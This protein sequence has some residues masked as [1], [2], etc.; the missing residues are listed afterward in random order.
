VPLRLLPV[1]PVAV[2]GCLICLLLLRCCC[3]YDCC[4]LLTLY[5]C[6]SCWL[7]RCSRCVYCVA[8]LFRCSRC[9]IYLLLLL[10]PVVRY[11]C[12]RC[13]F[14]T[15]VCCCLHW[16]DCSTLLRCHVVPIVTLLP[17]VAI[18]VADFVVLLTPICYVTRVITELFTVYCSHV[19]LL[20]YAIAVNVT[21]CQPRCAL[22]VTVTRYVVVC[23][24]TR[25]FVVCYVVVPL[26][27][28]G[29]VIWFCAD[30]RICLIVRFIWLIYDLL[31]LRSC[32]TLLLLFVICCVCL[33]GWFCCTPLAPH[34]A[35]VP[36]CY[37]RC[38][39]TRC[40]R[41]RARFAFATRYVLR[42]FTH[43][44]AL[45]CYHVTAPHVLPY[46]LFAFVVWLH[47]L[48]C[49]LRYLYALL[50]T[51]TALRLLPGRL[52]CLVGT[53]VA[54]LLRFPLLR[55]TFT[56]YVCCFGRSRCSLIRPDFALLRCSYRL[57][58]VYVCELPL[59]C[60]LV[61]CLLRV[62]FVDLRCYVGAV[63]ERYVCCCTLR[64]VVTILPHVYS[65][66]FVLERLFTIYLLLFALRYPLFALLFILLFVVVPH[67]VYVV[68]W[69]YVCCYA[70]ITLRLLL[71]YLLPLLLTLLLLRYHVVVRCRCTFVRFCTLLRCICLVLLPYCP[72]HLCCCSCCSVVRCWLLFDCCGTRSRCCS[73][74]PRLR[75]TL[76]LF[77][78]LGYLPRFLLFVC[79]VLYVARYVC[80]AYP[81]SRAPF[82][83]VVRY[84]PPVW[85]S[86]WFCSL[87]TFVT[88]RYRL[89]HTYVG[90]L[91]VWFVTVTRLI[92]VRLRCT[93][94]YDFGCVTVYYVC[95]LPTYVCVV[96]AVVWLPR[97][98]VVIYVCWFVVWM[99][100]LFQLRSRCYIAFDYVCCWFVCRL[101]SRWF[102]CDSI[103][104]AFVV[105]Y[106]Y[107]A[108][109]L[110]FT[111]YV[112]F[113][114]CW[115]R[116][117]WFVAL[118]IVAGVPL[119]WLPV[120]F[121][122]CIVVRCPFIA[123]SLRC[124]YVDFVL[125]AV[126][127]LPVCFVVP[128]LRTLWFT[129][130]VVVPLPCVVY[131]CVALFLFIAHLYVAVISAFIR[132]VVVV[133]LYRYV[134]VRCSFICCCRC[135]ITVVVCY[136]CA[137]FVPTLLLFVYV[138]AFTRLRL[139]R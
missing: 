97:A 35:F 119:R 44:A 24:T 52:R 100:R 22:H 53:F 101:D 23:Y 125:I 5:I 20:R 78:R 51:L 129:L 42:T 14:V 36:L 139:P 105:G 111:F 88:L 70:L 90:C 11:D 85:V 138:H 109:T 130:N 120:T 1:E 98:F 16:C 7:S 39:F 60:L 96:R 63:V 131:V 25:S 117:R 43:C 38:T 3:V 40:V 116:C 91:P 58:C 113:V 62:D 115:P 47:A 72:L 121:V 32:H 27:V 81:D 48:F 95:R 118:P 93:F 9:Y 136:V 15:F 19:A 2:A 10:L 126:L 54:P 94:V 18:V 92:C 34:F 107:C 21:L 12:C 50:R 82:T 127:W 104:V 56:R 57:H 83:V 37:T 41:L 75:F 124:V 46:C 73:R 33:I 55:C 49:R 66:L 80:I 89:P 61:R 84:L 71:H 102:V 30:L 76:P 26:P 114:G 8:H 65:R 128:T 28:V 45:R 86:L 110:P 64:V 29:V 87:F 106:R 74:L 79:F 69:L 6:C 122:R 4:C 133:D 112:A 103:V 108:V 99:P 135:Y 132:Y 31:L 134:A 137:R 13:S 17:V 67:P 59:R 77:L 68:C 123:D